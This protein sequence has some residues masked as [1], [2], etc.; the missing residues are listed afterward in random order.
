VAP[1]VLEQ[2]ASHWRV[3][4]GDAFLCQQPPYHKAHTTGGD[5]LLL[6][7]RISRPCTRRSARTS[8]LHRP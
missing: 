1:H 4:T 8:I 7:R 3:L 5:Y 6:A 2:V